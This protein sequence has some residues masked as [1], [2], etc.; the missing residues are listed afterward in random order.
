MQYSDKVID[1]FMNPRNV[2]EIKDANGIICCVG[3]LPVAVGLRKKG[4][5][6]GTVSLASGYLF[7]LLR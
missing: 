3:S 4:I 6:L 2:G 7:S 5:S 1:H